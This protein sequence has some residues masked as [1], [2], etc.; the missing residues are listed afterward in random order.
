[1]T[2]IDGTS[3]HCAKWNRQS[4]L[5]DDVRFWQAG[6]RPHSFRICDDIRD[7]GPGRPCRPSGKKIR[8]VCEPLTAA[9]D[10][11]VTLPAIV[12]VP[13]TNPA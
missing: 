8:S 10:W 3:T 5:K 12:N 2:R 1:M 6:E 4:C 13:A 11:L 9:L 7:K